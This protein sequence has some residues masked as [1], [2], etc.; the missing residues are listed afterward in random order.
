[1]V[2]AEIV[3]DIRQYRHLE[4]GY[5]TAESGCPV[6]QFALLQREW[7]GVY[8]ARP[9]QSSPFTAIRGTAVAA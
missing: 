7:A 5:G 6:S 8:M 3:Y 2:P 1:M 4:R 9:A